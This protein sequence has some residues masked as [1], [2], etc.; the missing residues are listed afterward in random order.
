MLL[1]TPSVFEGIGLSAGSEVHSPARGETSPA[2]PL[3]E[4]SHVR[5]MAES[6]FLRVG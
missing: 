1:A 3:A 2:T 5:G 4:T 6:P